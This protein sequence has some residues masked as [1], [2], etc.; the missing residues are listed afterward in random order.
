MGKYVK[1]GTTGRVNTDVALPVGTPG[2]N[3]PAS[4]GPGHASGAKPHPLVP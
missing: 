3:G 2:A 4:R 1:V